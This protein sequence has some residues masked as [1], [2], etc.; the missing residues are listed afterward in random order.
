MKDNLSTNSEFNLVIIGGSAGS[1]ETLF[2]II[3]KLPENFPCPVI[4]VIHRKRNDDASL[5][6][7]LNLKSKLIVKEAQE[8]EKIKAGKVYIAPAD[9]HLLIETDF[10]FSLD[11]GAKVNYSRPSIDVTF[12]CAANVYSKNSIGVLLSGANEDGALGLARIKKTKGLTIVEDP[13]TASIA[14]MP[15]AAIDKSKVDFILPVSKIAEL[16][17]KLVGGNFDKEED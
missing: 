14:T 11:F 13:K 8:K 3:P 7:M 9:Y 5:E 6:N 15:Q 10:T 1:I 12:T 4:V 16:L 2:K 17:I